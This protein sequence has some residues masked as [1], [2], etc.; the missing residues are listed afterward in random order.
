MRN[1]RKEGTKEIS[2]GGEKGGKRQWVE[3][4]DLICLLPLSVLDG[5]LL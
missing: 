4:A 2:R 3:K 5:P 1:A